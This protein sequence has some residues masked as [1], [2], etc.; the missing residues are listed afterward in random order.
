M[1]KNRYLLK[2][3]G[4]VLKGNLPSGIS[5]EFLNLF[6]ERLAKIILKKEVELGIVVGGGNIFRGVRGELEGFDR[7]YGDGV[8]MMATV[9]NSLLI[10][11]R[12]RY[13]NIPVL[14]QSAVK[15]EG[16][17][18]LFNRDRVEEVFEKNGC[19]VFCGGTGNPFFSTDTTAALRA[20]QINSDCLFKATKV[21]GIYDKD[22]EK[23]SGAKKFDAISYDEIISREIEV[24][25]LTSILMLKKNKQKLMVFNMNDNDSLERACRGEIVGTLV[26]ES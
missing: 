11:E 10:T 25:D 22:P 21:D 14:L 2:I 5:L 12:L 13:R 16:I 23:F 20:L 19:V 17:V 15:I 24:M 8:G 3:S 7:L 1:K 9:V 26:K 4:E 6:C 18:D